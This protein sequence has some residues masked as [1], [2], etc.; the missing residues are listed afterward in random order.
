M[1]TSGDRKLLLSHAR[2]II[3]NMVAVALCNITSRIF[4]GESEG[5]IALAGL[6]VTLPFAILFSSIGSLIGVG[7]ASR[8]AVSLQKK[9]TEEARKILVNTLLTTLFISLL[10]IVIF[11]TLAK[12]L[13]TVFGGRADTIPYAKEYLYYF[14]PGIIFIHFIINFTNC[15]RVSGFSGK[16]VKILIT[17]ILLNAALSPVFIYGLGW[18]IKGSALA[19]TV[20]MLICTIPVLRHFTNKNN[21]LYFQARY[22]KP[23]L[24]MIL[25]IIGSGMPPFFMNM[26]I[27][28][29]S[30]IMNNYLVF[31]GGYTAVGAYGIISSYSIVIMMLLSGISQGMQT[32]IRDKSGSGSIRQV[33]L[34]TFR[35]CAAITCISFITGELFTDYMSLLFTTDPT[36]TELTQSGLR[37]TFC[38]LPILGFQFV[39]ANF[40]QSISKARQAIFMNL[41]RQFLFLIPTLFIFSELW[42]VTGI[43]WAIPFSDLL[44]TSVSILFLRN[45]KR[46]HARKAEIIPTVQISK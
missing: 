29:V 40:F 26:T 20:S 36:L 1:N 41:S 33:L 8:I 25:K 27:C 18:G 19:T 11:F 37:I 10:L 43:W 34:T 9:N 15:M 35:L 4:I 42:Q 23:D 44:A 2:P 6:A 16:S 46:N 3:V 13:I 32:V 22:L 7:A 12:P 38:T 21:L 17:G 24:W 30:I 39:T 28:T 45:E 31:C 5:N 14:I